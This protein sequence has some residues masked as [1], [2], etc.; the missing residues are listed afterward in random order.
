[1]CLRSFFSQTS[2]VPKKKE[3]LLNC[4]FTASSRSFRFAIRKTIIHYFRRYFEFGTSC[5]H[6][7]QNSSSQLFLNDFFD[8]IVYSDNERYRQQFKAPLKRKLSSPDYSI[9]IRLRLR[10][11]GHN[12]LPEVYLVLKLNNNEIFPSSLKTIRN[13]S[14]VLTAN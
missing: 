14:E 6:S 2:F 12:A 1:M 9:R 11:S 3:S 8:L 5:H 10:L 4:C 13:I 7:T